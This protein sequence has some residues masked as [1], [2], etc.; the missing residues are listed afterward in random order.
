MRRRPFLWVFMAAALGFSF[1]SACGEKQKAL[2]LSPTTFD[3]LPA[4]E[5]DNVSEALPAL[6]RS[7]SI[8]E[9][10]NPQKTFSLKE[11]GIIQDWLRPCK[12]AQNIAAQD[13]A[14]YNEKARAFFEKNFIPYKIKNVRSGLFTGYYE[15]ALKGAL[16]KGGAFQTPLYP[17]PDDLITVNLG[18][19]DGGLKGKKI[20]GKNKN[21][22]L[23]P[24]DHRAAI[25][26]GSLTGRVKPLLWT[27]DSVTAFFLEIQGS[28][29]VAL[30]PDQEIHIGYV[31]QNGHPYVPVGRV[32][33]E[34]GEIERPVSMAKIR[35]W[36][37][38]NPARQQ[39][40]MNKNPSTVFFRPLESGG[41]EGAQGLV[42]TPLRSLAVDPRYVP[43][44]APLWLATEKHHRLVVAQD[45]GG[46]IKGL[47]RGDLFWGYGAA[48]E[49][50]AGEMQEK[51]TFY[52]L[53]PKTAEKP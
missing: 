34:A 2:V 11:A 47:V 12:E 37:A 5:K 33:L 36:F 38:K 8:F 31:A 10:R 23:I 43:L 40:I 44:G 41:A 3:Q 15:A 7:C 25:A 22:K 20:V 45:T 18:D 49:K 21:G 29:R 17:R 6:L 53:L 1:F 51:G 16:K 46:A 42:L 52:L 35:D 28:G 50:G 26:Q 4:W 39:E 32:L 9:A 14:Q 27:D 24:Y 30:G 48:A 19:F 13:L